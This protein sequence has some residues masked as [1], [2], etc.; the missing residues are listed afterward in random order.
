MIV[1]YYQ[2]LLSIVN[3]SR[4][5]YFILLSLYNNFFMQLSLSNICHC[6]IKKFKL[7]DKTQPTST[8]LIINPHS[9]T[10]LYIYNTLSAQLLDQS[11]A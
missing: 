10:H 9:H 7:N 11:N 6:F 2:L 4:C 1:H 3:V 5:D 8:V